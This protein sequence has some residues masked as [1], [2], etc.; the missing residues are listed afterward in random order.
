MQ[1]RFGDRWRHD[2]IERRIE[3]NEAIVLGKLTL[4][5][6]VVR[7]Q[8]GRATIGGGASSKVA[9]AAGVTFSLGSTAG[10]ALDREDQAFRLA[11]DDAL[12]KSARLFP[13]DAS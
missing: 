9:S 7:T 8:F 4:D 11:A 1:A 12:E 5:G 10:S 13:S 2:I 6:Q 3:G